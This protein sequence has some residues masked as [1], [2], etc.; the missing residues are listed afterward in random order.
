MAATR[1]IRKR[2]KSFSAAA[3]QAAPADLTPDAQDRLDREAKRHAKATVARSLETNSQVF[4]QERE[5]LERWA[6]DMV[7]AAEK[8][9]ADTKAQ[10]KA[11][12]RQSR[13]ATT[14]DEQHAL[15]NKFATL[16]KSS[17]PSASTSSTSKTK[18]KPSAT[19]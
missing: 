7:L 14:V 12:N 10:I 4:P 8:E 5:R 3:A 6:D 9:L 15:Q 11:L 19:C 16:K 13:L 2:A 18:S 17:A 1:W